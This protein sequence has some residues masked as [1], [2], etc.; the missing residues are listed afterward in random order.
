MA[1]PLHKISE[2]E[3]QTCPRRLNTP[4]LSCYIATTGSTF[5][6]FVA[7]MWGHSPQPGPT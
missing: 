7:L 3:K 6:R 1:P 5:T 2:D 4:V